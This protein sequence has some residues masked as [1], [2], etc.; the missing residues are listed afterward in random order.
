MLASNGEQFFLSLN[1]V[2]NVN[3]GTGQTHPTNARD[4]TLAGRMSFDHTTPTH[5]RWE[6]MRNAHMLCASSHARLHCVAR[7]T[8]SE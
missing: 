3:M 6:W 8:Y 2:N 7:P 5:T 1:N 4:V